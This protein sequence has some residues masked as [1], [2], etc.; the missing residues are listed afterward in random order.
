MTAALFFARI[1][2][3]I[4]FEVLINLSYALKGNFF[5]VNACFQ[6]Y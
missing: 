1:S 3:I 2:V 5:C 6:I 4:V